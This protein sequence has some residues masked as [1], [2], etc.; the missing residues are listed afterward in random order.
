M[1]RLSLFAIWIICILCAVVSLLWM[2]VA[3]A[4]DSPRAL[5]IALGFDRTGNATS[6][7]QDGEYLSSRANRARK[8][9][10]R[11]GCWLCKLLDKLR[12]GHCES[13]D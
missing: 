6:G 7:G 13:F 4:V 2:A 1:K 12:P 3:I 10:R 8:E 5:T 11:W 9:G